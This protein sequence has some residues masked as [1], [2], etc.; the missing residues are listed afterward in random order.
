MKK[1]LL[2]LF[3]ICATL[4]SIAQ[5]DKYQKAMEQNVQAIDSMTNSEG[6]LALS[7]TFSRIAEAEKTQ[8][9]PFYYASLTQVLGGL[10][11]STSGSPADA[12]VTDP[13]A[14][15]AEAFINKAEA[16]E[17]NNSEIFVVKKMIATLRMMADPMSRWQT[18]G[19]IGSEALA[20][21]K[22]LNPDNPRVYMLEGQ[23]KFY[24]PVEFGGSKEEAKKLFEESL[25]KFESSKPESSIHPQWGIRQVKYFHSQVK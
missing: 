15:K 5:T 25:R 22:K 3:I 20:T 11:S 4:G 19:P 18:Y 16:L 12:S 24:T 8:W 10:M 23:D 17:K 6:L 21:A 13:I 7:N 1:T 14:D 2:L 9:L